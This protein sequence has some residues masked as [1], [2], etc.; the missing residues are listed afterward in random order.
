[1]KKWRPGHKCLYV[2][3][4][5]GGNIDSLE[6]ILNRVLPLRKF[7][8]QEDEIIFLGGYLG[9]FEYGHKVL[10]TLLTIRNEYKGR[11]TFLIG[12]SEHR[13]LRAIFGDENEYRDWISCGGA[14]TIQGY[15]DR[16]SIRSDAATLPQ[17][18]LKD[19]VP[20]S[21]IEFLQSLPYSHTKDGY[22]FVYGGINWKLPIAE[23]NPVSFA[24]D[25]SFYKF[26]RSLWKAGR[27]IDVERVVVAAYTDGGVPIAYPKYM[28]L[29]MD[30]PKSLLCADLN[31]MQF[32]RAKNGKSRIYPVEIKICE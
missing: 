16:A 6:V 27:E 3:P 30:A 31:S 29:G 15:L 18:R 32:V 5:V 12:S 4:Q 22:L 21:H 1:M 19:V 13:F 14:N 7:I 2:I 8:G 20:R 28:A 24:L 17:S 9:G 11:A 25:T 10:D 23:N 26:Y